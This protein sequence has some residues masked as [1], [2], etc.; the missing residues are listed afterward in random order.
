[1]RKILR[2]ITA[3]IV[4]LAIGSTILACQKVNDKGESTVASTDPFFHSTEKVVFLPDENVSLSQVSNIRVNGD[5]VLITIQ[6]MYKADKAALEDPNYDPSERMGEKTFVCSISNGTVT[7]LDTAGV[8]KEGMSMCQSIAIRPDGLA[9]AMF[10]VF[11]EATYEISTHWFIMNLSTGEAGEEVTYNLDPIFST[12]VM[13]F[14]IDENGNRYFSSPGVVAV[15]DSEGDQLMYLDDEEFSGQLSY[16]D[17]KVYAAKCFENGDLLYYL[18]DILTQKASVPSEDMNFGQ[19]I[20]LDGNSYS[21]DGGKLIADDSGKEIFSWFETDA[22]LSHYLQRCYYAVLSPDTIGA[23]GLVEKGDQTSV[24]C[25]FLTKAK[26]NPHAGKEVLYVGGVQLIS[27]MD[28]MAAVYEYNLFSDKVYIKVK[29]YE[30]DPAADEENGISGEQSLLNLQKQ[31]YRD[32]KDDNNIDI[33]MNMGKYPWFSD[34]GALMDLSDAMAGIIQDD[35]YYGNLISAFSEGNKIYQIP[36]SVNISGLSLE[37]DVTFGEGMTWEEMATYLSKHEESCIS[38]SQYQQQDWLSYL[39]ENS[40]SEISCKDTQSSKIAQEA[41]KSIL[42]FAKKNGKYSDN[43]TETT[44]IRTESQGSE[45]GIQTIYH[46]ADVV[47][48][49][50]YQGNPLSLV[51]LPS[52]NGNGLGITSSLSVAVSAQCANSEAAVEFVKL[53]L[54]SD[55]QRLIAEN[56]DSIPVRCDAVEFQI[57]NAIDMSESDPMFSYYYSTSPTPELAEQ[58]RDIIQAANQRNGYDYEVFSII[59]EEAAAYFADKK[60]IE[61]VIAIIDNRIGT[62]QKEKGSN[63]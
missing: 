36:I 20:S 63:A 22:N 30:W 39:L 41:M 37:E 19:V 6:M 27:D 12:G 23:V 54:S 44:A 35:A 56:D 60:S 57:N 53:L 28:L 13:A 58:Y 25:N 48:T 7:T 3:L 5:V 26:E 42:V 55:H 62:L 45:D 49:S 34:D 40:E 24:Y 46:F 32:I 4:V 29:N 15:Y 1:M 14:E 10:I 59:K 38:L 47:N 11:D 9:E 16:V 33:V 43:W 31:I 50:Y 18:V 61:E 52:T 8:F 17:G 2:R 51:G 21:A